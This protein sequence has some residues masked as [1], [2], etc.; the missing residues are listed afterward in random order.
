MIFLFPAQ[1]LGS[2]IAGLKR[3]KNRGGR[4]VLGPSQI[5]LAPSLARISPTCREQKRWAPLAVAGIGDPGLHLS[6]SETG[7]NDAGYTYTDDSDDLSVLLNLCYLRNSRFLIASPGATL[8]WIQLAETTAPHLRLQLSR[9]SVETRSSR[10]FPMCSPK[11]APEEAPQQ[12]V[13]LDVL[14]NLLTA[15]D[16]RFARKNIEERN[17]LTPGSHHRHRLQSAGGTENPPVVASKDRYACGKA[18]DSFRARRNRAYSGRIVSDHQ[19]P[20]KFSVLLPRLPIGT[21]P[22]IRRDLSEW[23]RGREHRLCQQKT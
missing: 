5:H 6:I 1:V 8:P 16:R 10:A 11:A 15:G 22:A 20:A 14:Q 13:R 3:A 23:H 21:G 2:M 9:R 7:I 17:S 4:G 19:A 18:R 12:D